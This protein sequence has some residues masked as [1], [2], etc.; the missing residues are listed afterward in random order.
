MKAI[1]D[2]K[3][4]KLLEKVA[5]K[6]NEGREI[7]EEREIVDIAK[8]KIRKLSSNLTS[9]AASDGIDLSEEE[10]FEA[11]EPNVGRPSQTA[12]PTSNKVPLPASILKGAKG[13][14]HAPNNTSD[15]QQVKSDKD[16]QL[17]DLYEELL[18]KSSVSGGKAAA[19]EDEEGDFKKSGRISFSSAQK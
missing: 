13:T 8:K 17:V 4:L 11:R 16:S 9:I 7:S 1:R 5:A 12:R 6:G 18:D 10:E 2:G 3:K 14:H 15:P 19:E